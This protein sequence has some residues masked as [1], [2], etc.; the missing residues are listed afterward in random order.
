MTEKNDLAAGVDA[1][2]SEQGAFRTVAGALV[3]ELADLFGWSDRSPLHALVHV[4]NAVLNERATAAT[5]RRYCASCKVLMRSQSSA[6]A[7]T[8]RT[9]DESSAVQ[10]KP[11]HPPADPVQLVGQEQ[12]TS[13]PDAWLRI[14]NNSGLKQC[15]RCTHVA[16]EGETVCACC[17]HEPVDDTTWRAESQPQQHTEP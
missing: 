4:R 1:L 17:G 9:S 6:E 16:L 13:E 11:N 12:Q 7:I 10:P 8:K 15:P 2:D 5:E 3:D 14:A